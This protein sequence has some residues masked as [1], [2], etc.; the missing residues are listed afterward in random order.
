MHRLCWPVPYPHP[1]KC[2][3]NS[4]LAATD[5]TKKSELGMAALL[6]YSVSGMI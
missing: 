1:I 4:E 6:N 2:I 3:T 5:S